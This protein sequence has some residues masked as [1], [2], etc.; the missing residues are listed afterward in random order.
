VNRAVLPRVTVLMP[1]Y[2]G[3]PFLADAIQSILQQTFI[4][5]E[6]LIIN[7]GSTDDSVAII[8]KFHDPRIRLIHNGTNQGLVAS[9]N[10]GM[11]LAQGEYIAR[12]DADDVSRPERLARQVCFMDE[13][14]K[15]GVCGSWVQFFPKR[16]NYVWKL[17]E[18]SEEIRCWQFHTVGV[19]HPSVIMRRKLFV[20][21]GLLYD[22]EYRHIEDYELWSRALN[23]MEFANIQTVLLD[24]R[25]SPGQICAEH[26]AA[27][28]ATVAPLRLQ[29]VRELGL[30]PTPDELTL[31]EMVMNGFVSS[32][33]EFLDRAEE[34]LLR[35]GSANNLV[36]NYVVALFNKRL[37]EIWFST[38]ANHSAANV[39]SWKRCRQSV[40]WSLANVTVWCR[41]CALASWL[42][43]KGRR[44]WHGNR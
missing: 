14:P 5:L 36:G 43:L 23:Y 29:R 34:W 41:A 38:C 42:T 8:Q 11:G 44:W 39:C 9:L 26:G 40:L 20:E 37:F 2:N 16:N 24:Y 12:M 17:P 32:D 6:F 7:D 10:L 15:V 1:V 21:H 13:N 18:K 3:A 25:I 28:A 30:E 22:P 19:A 33:R 4:D 35:L 27:Q 31:H